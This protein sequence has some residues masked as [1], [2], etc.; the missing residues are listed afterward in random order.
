MEQ[1]HVLHRSED[2]RNF[3]RLLVLVL[4]A[5]GGH[6]LSKELQAENQHDMLQSISLLSARPFGEL[7]A[8][9]VSQFSKGSPEPT[10]SVSPGTL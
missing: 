8:T 7:D 2:G 9:Y 10:A 5:R 3:F 4:C 1:P 6:G